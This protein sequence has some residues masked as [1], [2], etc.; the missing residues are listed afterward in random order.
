MMW[1]VGFWFSGVIFTFTALIKTTINPVPLKREK[2]NTQLNYLVQGNHKTT[3]YCYLYQYSDN[4]YYYP[5]N[6]INNLNITRGLVYSQ[7]V[8]LALTNKGISR[9]DA[10]RIVQT[11]AME[12]WKDKSK[13]LKSE[14]LQSEEVLKYLSEKEVEELFDPN[15]MLD[16]V[17]YIFSRTFD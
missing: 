10:Y 17:E 6:C 13:S 12:V 11:N 15:N 1:K 7:T 3:I 2:I 4:H 5:E 16:N 8:L 9:E 14:L